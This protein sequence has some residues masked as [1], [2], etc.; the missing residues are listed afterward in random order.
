MKFTTTQ[1]SNV[2][3]K[4]HFAATITFFYNTKFTM[5]GFIKKT[6]TTR[7][8]TTVTKTTTRSSSSNGEKMELINSADVAKINPGGEIATLWD[9]DATS[10][11][12]LV[13]VHPP[14]PGQTEPIITKVDEDN[15][16]PAVF[17]S[18]EKPD[19][20]I[21][22]TWIQSS[23]FGT[24]GQFFP[25]GGFQSEQFL[26]GLKGSISLVTRTSSSSSATTTSTSTNN[27][28]IRGTVMSSVSGTTSFLPS[29]PVE[30]SMPAVFY[31]NPAPL[32]ATGNGTAPKFNP[33]PIMG[34][35]V[36]GSGTTPGV[37]TPNPEEAPKLKGSTSLTPGFVS[38]PIPGV[39][40]IAGN[41]QP[42]SNKFVVPEPIVST[43][44]NGAIKQKGV[45]IYK[46]STHFLYDFYMLFYVTGVF[47][48]FGSP[49][50]DIPGSFSFTPPSSTGGSPTGPPT[51]IPDSSPGTPQ[52]QV[53]DHDGV[54]IPSIP[55]GHPVPLFVSSPAPGTFTVKTIKRKTIKCEHKYI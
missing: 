24:P 41:L 20:K 33:S 16:I 46:K 3:L 21:S 6:T 12:V 19:L 50:V 35:W 26:M 22:G 7:T 14:G 44:P 23:T 38:L 40:P 17:S 54:F 31:P 28:V 52:L 10:K 34:I 4:N 48:K 32:P 43:S 45:K 1:V 49:P 30:K 42:G 37:F 36:P 13:L 25:D 53:G 11:P 18:D 2:A 39:A 5:T 15:P 29:A 9:G 51:F 47:H 8:T 55:N 27:N